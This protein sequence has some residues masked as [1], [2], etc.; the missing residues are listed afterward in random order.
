MLAQLTTLILL[1]RRLREPAAAGPGFGWFAVLPFAV[2][3]CWI[4]V[5]TIANIRPD[6]LP[7]RIP[8]HT[9]A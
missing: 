5:A 9:T 2:Y 6:A 4:T 8:G 1:H 7:R 3:P